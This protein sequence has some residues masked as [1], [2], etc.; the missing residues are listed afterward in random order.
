MAV[1]FRVPGPVTI[2]WNSVDLGSTKDGV[3][4]AIQTFWRPVTAD[5]HGSQPA[6]YIMAGKSA[7]ISATLLEAAA[8]KS[9]AAAIG[10]LLDAAVDTSIGKLSYDGNAAVLAKAVVVTEADGATWTAPLCVPL[11]PLRIALRST[12]ELQLPLQFLV[13][14]DISTGLLITPPSYLA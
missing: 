11:D 14:P 9:A 7:V 1:V 12:E 5:K 6:D 3:Q 10:K 13:T 8:Y 4:V 2:S